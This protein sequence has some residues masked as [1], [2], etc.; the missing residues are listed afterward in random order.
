MN[1]TPGDH[2]SDDSGHDA[3]HDSRAQGLSMVRGLL[4]DVGLPIIAYYA[5]HALGATD[6]VALLAASGVAAL[7]LLYGVLIRREINQF[8]VVMLLIYGIGLVLALTTGDPRVLLLKSSFVTG[9]VALVF[10]GTA[11]FG[12]KPLTLSAQQSFMPAKAAEFEEEYNTIPEARR[13]YK[14]VSY[15]WGLGLLAE[16]IIRIPIV[17]LL[18]IDIG[19]G[20][21]EALFVL[22]FVLLGGWTFWYQRHVETA[23]SDT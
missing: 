23:A 20:L 3:G 16:A 14:L 18:P 5:L 15:V 12:R 21:S 8:A 11:A 22:A 10:L 17:Y 2:T 1:A 4:I 13:A 19:Y 9:A 7:R 6:W